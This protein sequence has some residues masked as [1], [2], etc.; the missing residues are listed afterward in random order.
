MSRRG[1]KLTQSLLRGFE[2]DGEA[3][4]TL[5]RV[6]HPFVVFRIVGPGVGVWLVL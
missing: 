1:H 3:P 6:G 4:H 2:V 5:R